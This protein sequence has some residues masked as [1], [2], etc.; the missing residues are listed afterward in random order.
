MKIV[1]PI[2]DSFVPMEGWLDA[3]WEGTNGGAESGHII[4]R[5]G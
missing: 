2:S 1:S 3:E 4:K 5:A